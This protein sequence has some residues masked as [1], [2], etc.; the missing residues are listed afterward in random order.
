[1]S[2]YRPAVRQSVAILLSSVVAVGIAVG[3]L[4]VRRAAG[5]APGPGGQGCPSPSPSTSPTSSPTG[6]TTILT[7]LPTNTRRTTASPTSS[8]TACPSRVDSRISIAY[9]DGARSFN[10]RVTSQRASCET[11]RR[12]VLK[13]VRRGADRVVGNDVSDRRGKWEVKTARPKGRFY[14]NAKR[15]FVTNGTIECKKARSRTIRP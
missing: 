15:R 6:I 4:N 2:A 9:N 12:V 7:V 3:V 11:N 1:M 8:P 14:A 10:G 13:K 5:V